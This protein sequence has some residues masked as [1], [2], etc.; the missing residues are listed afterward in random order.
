M[1]ARVMRNLSSDSPAL[2]VLN[3]NWD[4]TGFG[5]EAGDLACVGGCICVCARLAEEPVC[6]AD[7][8]MAGEGDFAF[9]GEDVDG[10]F[11][12]VGD[13]VDEDGFGEIE[14]ESYDV[15]LALGELLGWLFGRKTT[16]SWLPLKGLVVKTSRVT[17][18][19]CV[20]VRVGCLKGRRNWI[21]IVF[22]SPFGCSKKDIAPCP[23]P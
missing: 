22:S 1:N 13:W 23:R 14:F 9:N 21:Q 18:L 16:A 20:M 19:S 7:G 15:L 4:F 5:D 2:R 17:N 8:G 10:A 3:G 6:G 12:G 11:G